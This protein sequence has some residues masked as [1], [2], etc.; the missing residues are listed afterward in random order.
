ML[1][2]VAGS[3]WGRGSMRN[4]IFVALLAL[5]AFVGTA[6]AGTTNIGYDSRGRISCV[7]LPNGTRISYFYD[8]SDN[9][10]STTV[11]TNTCVSKSA[12]AI[13]PSIPQA[14]PPPPPPPPAN[15]PQPISLSPNLLSYQINSRGVQT[16][17]V[18]SLGTSSD[19]A[20]LSI[21]AAATSGTAGQCGTVT[22]TASQLTYTATL[23]SPET[24]RVYCYVSFQLRHPNGATTGA[25]IT[26]YIIGEVDPG[27][28]GGGG[29]H[30]PSGG[31]PNEN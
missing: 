14:L 6:T 21:V 27:G 9:R 31:C 5:C 23:I 29:L 16:T 20:T 11:D 3:G 8:S 24:R 1:G 2:I 4:V 18:A 7:K 28:S 17:S 19:G 12:G 22:Y 30:C 15:I 25:T 10:T 13:P 26:Y